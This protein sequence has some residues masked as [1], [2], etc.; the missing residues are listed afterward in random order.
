MQLQ[1][2]RIASGAKMQTF[3][4]HICPFITW[5]A[6]SG[7]IANGV[8]EINNKSNGAI[9]FSEHLCGKTTHD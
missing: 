9:L 6:F 7:S 5:G 3:A 2:R 4:S 8:G 1:M